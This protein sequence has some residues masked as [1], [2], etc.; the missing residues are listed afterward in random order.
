MMPAYNKGEYI[1]EAINSVLNQTYS[2]WEL[3]IV[4]D[5]STDNTNKIAEEFSKKDN[6]IKYHRNN[7][8]LG[9]PK[10][11]N[12]ALNLA[13]G[14]FMGFIDS[15]DRLVKNSLKRASTYIKKYPDV[16]LFYSKIFVI[17]KEGNINYEQGKY[18]EKEYLKKLKVINTHLSIFNRNLAIECGGFNENLIT[19]SDT[20][21]WMKLYLKT[22]K[23]K[24]IDEPLYEYRI[25]DEN[26]SLKKNSL[27]CSQCRKYKYC[28]IHVAL[29]DYRFAGINPEDT[30]IEFVNQYF[31]EAIR[32]IK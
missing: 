20:N 31:P 24:Y 17:D 4:D 2:N 18:H 3:I 12:I 10:T 16:N 19:C 32:E 25:H 11:R 14:E 1:E 9:I 5:G 26:T 8:N 23:I 13:K 22:K 21:L 6:R 7:I 28:I 15:D 29:E 30:E 27:R